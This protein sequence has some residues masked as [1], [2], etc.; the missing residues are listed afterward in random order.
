MLLLIMSLISYCDFGEIYYWVHKSYINLMAEVSTKFE[1]FYIHK[2]D[3]CF[4]SIHICIKHLS[5]LGLGICV[6]G[7]KYKV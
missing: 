2:F 4:I 1:L 3:I 7:S 6:Y 5:P